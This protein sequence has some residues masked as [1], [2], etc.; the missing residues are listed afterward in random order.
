[1]CCCWESGAIVLDLEFR[2]R[3]SQSCVEGLQS[4]TSRYNQIEELKE[5]EVCCGFPHLSLSQSDLDL[6]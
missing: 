1:V 4:G 5:G 2:R 6:H 3:S